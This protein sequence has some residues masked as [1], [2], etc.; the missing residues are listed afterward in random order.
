MI[1]SPVENPTIPKLHLRKEVSQLSVT[2]QS[3]GN[4]CDR[5][6]SPMSPYKQNKL[7]NQDDPDATDSVSPTFKIHANFDLDAGQLAKQEVFRR[8]SDRPFRM[9]IIK[10]LES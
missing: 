8:K 7:R 9:Q 1:N 2:K 6:L 3:D 5:N 10:T 4:V